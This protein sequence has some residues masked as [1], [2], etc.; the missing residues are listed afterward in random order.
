MD[1]LGWDLD[2]LEIAVDMYLAG[3]GTLRF[4]D[5]VSCLSDAIAVE[6]RRTP[7]YRDRIG[8]IKDLIHR[9]E[10]DGVREDGIQ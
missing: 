3:R 8:R 7:K 4:A 10:R 1:Q 9:L 2:K 5:L 6:Q